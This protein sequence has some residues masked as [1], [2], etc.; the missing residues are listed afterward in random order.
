MAQESVPVRR[1]KCGEI[2]EKSAAREGLRRSWTDQPKNCQM[3]RKIP[4]RPICSTDSP[5]ASS[6]KAASRDGRD[7]NPWI[8]RSNMGLREQAEESSSVR[9]SFF[10]GCA[11]PPSLLLKS[12]L[13]NP[14]WR[15]LGP[16]PVVHRFPAKHPIEPVACGI[17]SS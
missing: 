14:S 6:S 16:L 7:E 17:S 10:E 2:L 5:P 13:G 4:K 8:A 12:L 11:P 1:G 9:A 15:R 3:Q